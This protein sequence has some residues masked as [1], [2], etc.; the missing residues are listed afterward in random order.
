MKEDVFMPRVV[1]SGQR[2]A[3][4][5]VLYQRTFSQRESHLLSIQGLEPVLHLVKSDGSREDIV[6][7]QRKCF[8]VVESHAFVGPHVGTHNLANPHLLNEVLDDRV[9][10]QYELRMCRILLQTA[11][12]LHH[13]LLVSR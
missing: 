7:Q 13:A 8:V 11:L 2:P 9:R 1:K 12:N 4:P 10:S 5:V 3:H 6:N